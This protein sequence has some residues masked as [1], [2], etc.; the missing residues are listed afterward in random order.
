MY[1]KAGARRH[2]FVAGSLQQCPKRVDRARDHTRSRRT[3]KSGTKH[4]TVAYWARRF[5]EPNRGKP[6]AIQERQ[7]TRDKAPILQGS[8]LRL[9]VLSL[10]N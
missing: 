9:P 5:A 3:L 1:R 8:F 10:P 6:G 4:T 7:S 2:F